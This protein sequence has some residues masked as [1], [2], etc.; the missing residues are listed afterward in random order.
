M[1]RAQFAERFGTDCDS[2][3]HPAHPERKAD[4]LIFPV[5]DHPRRHRARIH[6]GESTEA[7]SRMPP[8][9]ERWGSAVRATAE[10]R[11]GVYMSS[12]RPAVGADEAP[13]S[14]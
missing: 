13:E 5:L 1:T 4:R 2:F 11:G 8:T 6:Q 7:L 9:W 10:T 12:A 3:L 14:E